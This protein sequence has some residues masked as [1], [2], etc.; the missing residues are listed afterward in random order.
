MAHPLINKLESL[1]RLSQA[2]ITLLE[3]VTL[4]VREFATGRDIIAEGERPDHVH[5]MLGGWSCRYQILAE[6]ERQITAFLVPG[7]FCDA[8]ITILRR[9]DHGIMALTPASVA[10]ISRATMMKLAD[11][12]SIARALWWASLVD[13]AVLRAWIVN[14]GRRDAFTRIAH[15]VCE[16]FA[17]LRNVGL[18]TGDAFELPLTQVDL[19]DATSLTPVHVNRVLKRL[20]EQGLMTF[21][22]GH[23]V[24]LD[25]ARLRALSGF[26]VRY[27]HLA[28]QPAIPALG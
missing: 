27:L 13:E 5:L 15:L 23:V 8:H 9:M 17:R 16:M 12:P 3:D 1:G 24:I 20:R 11:R 19:A 25:I 26:D 22:A 7:D 6:G 2:D 28:S 10:F 21:R 14:M 18:T 4:D